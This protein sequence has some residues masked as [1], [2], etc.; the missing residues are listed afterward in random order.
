[1][2]NIFSSSIKTI[3]V[4]ASGLELNQSAKFG[5]SLSLTEDD[6]INNIPD[7]FQCTL[8]DGSQW[9]VKSGQWLQLAKGGKAKGGNE[10]W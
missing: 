4:C 7:K 8:P 2:F 9:S 1:M 3:H 10:S 6:C 5:A